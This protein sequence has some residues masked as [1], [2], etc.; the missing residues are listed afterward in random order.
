MA[1]STRSY[2][3]VAILFLAFA[4]HSSVTQVQSQPE[5]VEQHS[6]HVASVNDRFED[7]FGPA[8]ALASTPFLGLAAITGAALLI[9]Q[10]VFAE[11]SSPF[12]HRL[13]ANVVIREAKTYASWWLFA[14]FVL[15]AA[16]AA[17]VNSGKLQGAFGKFAHVAE[18]I[19]AGLAY[20][21]VAATALVSGASPSA[22]A[23]EPRILTASIVPAIEPTA[24][25]LVVAA[26]LA[27]AAMMIVRLAFDLLI[28]LNPIPFVDMFFQAL[29]TGFSVV[30]MVI[31]A[32][33]PFAAALCAAII[34]VPCL[35]LLPWAMR[36]LSFARRILIYPLLARA[37]PTLRPRLVDPVLSNSGGTG[38]PSLACHAN[39]LRARGLRKRQAVALVQVAGRTQI[40]PIRNRKKVRDLAGAGEQVVI[41]RAV[42]WIEVRVLGPDETLLDHLAL[43]YSLGGQY[44]DLCTL[45][46]ARD[47]GHF[48]MLKALRAAGRSALHGIEVANRSVDTWR[49]VR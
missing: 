24:F 15:L 35:V 46:S 41:G 33:S 26:G 25:A 38:Q 8:P 43:P 37:L 6:R 3:V 27:L 11:S 9:D 36:L 28:W 1:P 39:V 4:G 5:A 2:A 31:Y 22:A 12:V 13:R 19:A 48:G 7:V 16:L 23:L 30:F 17:I 40:V 47:E 49:S 21:L 44:K 45:L 10:P 34:L 42:A 29:K 14:L 20:V 32:W 18:S